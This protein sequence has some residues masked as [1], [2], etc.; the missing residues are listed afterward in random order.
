MIYTKLKF[1]SNL[2]TSPNFGPQN[3]YANKTCL[4]ELGAADGHFRSNFLQKDEM[5]V[6]KKMTAW[7][8]IK[9]SIGMKFQEPEW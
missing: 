5:K 1:H 8:K 9:M 6:E 3:F 4:V 2:S 7:L